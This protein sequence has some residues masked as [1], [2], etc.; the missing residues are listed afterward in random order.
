MTTGRINQVAFLHDVE[1]RLSPPVTSPWRQGSGGRQCGSERHS[2]EGQYKGNTFEVL[3]SISCRQM[4]C[5][6]ESEQPTTR[7]ATSLGKA[8]A[9]RDAGFRVRRAPGEGCR[10]KG[11]NETRR[12]HR[13]R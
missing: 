5:I 13:V 10:Q 3:S 9:E 7:A 8:K 4:H 1:T 2:F 6:R 11:T 12:F